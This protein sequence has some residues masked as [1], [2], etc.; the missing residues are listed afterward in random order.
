MFLTI[1]RLE[2]ATLFRRGTTYL[3]FAVLFVLAAYAMAS[4]A[5]QSDVGAVSRNAPAIVAQIL[6]GLTI[7]G[8]VIT[9]AVVGAAILRDV[10]YKA[11][12][13][14]FTTRVT[15]LGY[16]GG[17]FT[18]ALLAM[19][20]IYTALPL[21]AFVGT[22]MP[23]LD[24]DTLQAFHLST[25]TRPF[26]LLVIPNI[27]FVSALMFAV[28]ALTRNLFAIY[29]QGIVLL[30]GYA[31]SQI[32]LVSLD[33]L[34]LA[35]M[36]DPFGDT[37][38]GLATRYWTITE[39]NTRAFTLSGPLLT[40]RLIW[41]G[42]AAA[43]VA[44]T[45]ATVR[46]EAQPRSLT[47]RVRRRRPTDTPSPSL[48]RA[49]Q[50][51]R[52]PAVSL[53]FGLA[54]RLRQLAS[55]AQFFFVA[56]VREPVFLT[57]ACIGLV[58][59]ALGAWFVDLRYGTALWPVTGEMLAAIIRR[60]YLF[61][62]VITTIYAG[63]LVWRERQLG[64]AGTT[65][66]L[67]TPTWLTLAG[68]FI[69]FLGAM[70]VVELVA[71]LATLGVQTIKGY[72]HYQLGLYAQGVLG[73][74]MPTV[75]EIAALA[76]VVHALVNEKFVGHV[77]MIVYFLVTLALNKLG[78]QRVIYQYGFT[79][80]YV[81]SD[82]NHFRQY[83][84]SLSGLAL[85][86]VAAAIVLLI[87]AYLAW[88]RGADETIRARLGSALSRW[89]P[90]P[91]RLLGGATAC[92]TLVAGGLVWHNTAVINRFESTREVQHSRAAYERDFHRY[93]SL[94]GPRIVAVHV[95]A[96]LVPESRAMALSSIYTVV[97]K[98]SRPIDTLYA[99]L[100]S[101]AYHFTL[102]SGMGVEHNYHVD[103]LAWSRPTRLL[104]ADSARGVYLYRLLQPLAPGDSMTL[105]FG[106]HYAA[107]GYPN[108]SPNND[109][110]ANGTFLNSTFQ[111]FPSLCYQGNVELA[112]DDM[113][114]REHLPPWHGAPSLSD[115]SARANSTAT[116]DAD[117]VTF[118]A[119]LSTA[120]DQIAIAPGT[121]E[122]E[123]MDHGRRFFAYRTPRAIPKFYSI[124]SGRYVVRHDS[125]PGVA[126][127]VYYQPG[128]EV[129]VGRMIDG[130]KRGLAYYGAH[131]SPYQFPQ[132]RIVEFPRYQSFA[133]AFPGTIPFSE[134]L[135]FISR[136]RD[137]K[138]D[139]DWPL[140]AT[141]H[142]LGHQWWGE[143]ITPAEQQGAAMLVESLAEYSAL[144]VMEQKYGV[145]NLRKFLRYELDRYL[146][147]RATERKQEVPLMRAAELSQSY[148]F[149]NKGSLAFYALRDYIGEDSLN[150]ALHRYLHDK[151]FQYPPYTNTPE[152][153]AYLR[154]V[155]PDSLQYVIHDL[156]ETITLYDNRA[157][158]ATA[159]RLADG[160]YT[161]HLTFN[162]RKLRADS[163]GA[164]KDIP[165]ADYIDV[166]VFAGDRPLAVRKV[167][168]TQPA[169]SVDFVVAER[170]TKAGIDP[171]NK[172][173]DRAPEDNVRAVTITP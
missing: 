167:H 105:A 25:Y 121:L 102:S 57:I 5:V 54:A 99:S 26:F 11:H 95:R 67:P 168:V 140:F 172:L 84:A 9:T 59:M 148:V 127:D 160:R 141:A 150:A 74:A 151:A 72:H 145:S 109:L 135:G 50:P 154:A 173:I 28:G 76:F 71:V 164:E 166:G 77:I 34:Q 44:V 30:A 87:V 163:L 81:Y 124:Q 100:A 155:T 61:L 144:T 45:L 15:R 36:V 60:M 115:E 147:G 7:V 161:V 149:Y 110:V 133:E 4:D 64:V 146:V 82:M 70:L 92:A 63:E 14:L 58:F 79:P 152:L 111:Y 40:N 143:Q 48:T 106:A 101:A 43:L 12:E 56:I 153:L 49:P 38:L 78:F 22:L 47:W 125:A 97:N 85:Y 31:V 142:E 171:F 8:Q 16:L 159:T 46:L 2:L 20:A 29:T 117:W 35:G 94:A 116:C 136:V 24:R 93:E 138:N 18:G 3:Y 113:R 19:L 17:R 62:V 91:T 55:Q 89:R 126:I 158:A 120:P 122:R 75:I 10:Q 104:F 42:V 103:S 129:D 123:W 68:K 6:I 162:A 86:F 23:W 157:T 165:M 88:P 52:L 134:G 53:S 27:V 108:D 98:H 128:H 21:G 130:A 39:R 119:V 107:H 51:A 66:A 139:I 118:D 90:G 131:F 37:A 156:F 114:K 80:D 33:H 13:L 32:I 137:D 169:M 132:F 41:L 65:D 1:T 112:N 83:A 96:D 69:A 170:P 73:I